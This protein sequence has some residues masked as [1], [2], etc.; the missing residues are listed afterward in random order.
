MFNVLCFAVQKKYLCIAR[1]SCVIFKV[2]RALLSLRRRF[3]RRRRFAHE[4]EKERERKVFGAAA[5]Q[6]KKS[7]SVPSGPATNK[8]AFE[9]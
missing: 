1:E 8:H 4:K 7:P 6:T 9:I 5:K 2:C 3:R